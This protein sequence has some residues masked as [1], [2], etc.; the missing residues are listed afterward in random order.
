[1][2]F[3]RTKRFAVVA[4]FFGT[5]ASN[6][7][8]TTAFVSAPQTRSIPIV[9]TTKA[10]KTPRKTTSLEAAVLPV[11]S[12]GK[13]IILGAAGICAKKSIKVVKQG[14]I[15]IVERFGKFQT[16]LQPGLHFLIPFVDTIRVTL[17]NREQVLDIPPQNCIT[18]DNAPIKADAVVY[19]RIIDAERA[20]Y[21]VE[22]LSLAIQNLIL[23]QLRAEIGKLTLDM[24]F[25]AREQVNKVLLEELDVATDPWGV[26]ITRVEVR[27]IVPNREILQAMEQQMAAERTKRASIIKSEGERERSINEAEGRARSRIIDAEAAAKSLVVQADAKATQT[28]TEAIGVAKALDAIAKALA[29]GDDSIKDA[30]SNAAK[31]QL[32]REYIAAQRDLA[33]SNNAKVI[34]TGGGGGS[35]VDDVLGKAVAFYNTKD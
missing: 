24:T 14:D 27:D 17:T 21:A 4:L 32:V 29:E 23:T 1:M 33:T 2:I 25:S 18:S 13:S 11:Y 7:C 30:T 6:F 28:E 20:I 31:F 5:L 35:D 9:S 12:L 3:P 34:V 10:L 26:K 16:R 19:W 15:S 8:S 22:N